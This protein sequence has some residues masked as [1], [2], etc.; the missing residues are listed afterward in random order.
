[1]I[2]LSMLNDEQK[3]AVLDFDHNLL[4]L[5]CAG[6]G[7]TRTITAKIAYA[8]SE[9]IYKP[10]Q[11]L[12]VT[13]TNRAANEM[14]ER[15]AQYLPDEDL[16]GLEMRTFHSFG[17]Y[18]LRRNYERAGLP[19]DFCIYDDADSV[20]LLS[21]VAAM[22]KRELRQAMKDISNLKD[23]GVMPEDREAA[24]AGD[25]SYDLPQLYLK[26]QNALRKTGNVDFADL[27]LKPYELLRDDEEVR[28]RYNSR[29]RM[30]LVD[31]YQ[32]SN[33]MQFRLLR[34]LAGPDTQIVAVGDDDQSIYSFRGAAIENILTFS[35]SFENVREIKLEKN[36]RST[37]QI[38]SPA[39]AL[40]AHNTERHPKSLISADDKTGPKP[41]LL[42][43]PDAR[44]EG[45][46]IASIIGEI[47]D[48]D[49]TAIL[50]RTNAQSLIFEQ[51]LT[52]RRI[53]FKLIGALRFY[54]RE[55]IK[56]SLAF[57]Y[58]LLNHRDEI[59]FRRIVNKPARGLGEQKIS[60]ILSLSDDIK[61]GLRLFVSTASGAAA[62]G[63][64]LFL[65]AWDAADKSLDMDG[66]LGEVL[67]KAL[68][69][70]GLYG[71]YQ[72]ESDKAVRMTKLDN[73]GTLVSSLQEAG[74]GREDLASFL[75]KITLDATMIGDNDPADA[76]GVTLIT[77]HNT[78]GLEF[79]RVFIA[80]LE[81]GII[82]GRNGEDREA[83]EERRILYVAMTRARKYLYLSY[84]D[85]RMLWGRTEMQRPSR[86]LREIPQDMIAADLRSSVSQRPYSSIVN[87]PSW[88]SGISFEKPKVQKVKPRN[89]YGT[90]SVGDD[91]TNP[92]FGRGKVIEID[93]KGEGRRVITVRFGKSTAKFIE[94]FAK[95]EKS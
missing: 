58:L 8:I 43:N 85:R 95:L 26:Y 36:Y 27:I 35:S 74:N 20:S 65:S 22:E 3:E 49:N 63:A 81:D 7:K 48:Y 4:L 21:T 9:G 46:R 23:R 52:E 62:A 32:D 2:D 94:A 87:T 34:Q 57:L 60:R 67:R 93:D 68:D 29:F 42:R 53:P 90:F 83:E 28:T 45:V 78:K 13:F 71:L 18:M 69:D 61:E 72:S 16:S 91:V 12:A 44:A 41:Q 51:I 76:K 73:L 89:E 24:R 30:I 10:Y 1:M 66:N 88:A 82:P 79:D 39:A 64:S 59:S 25:G 92:E 5:A 54:E 19:R 70:T 40:I 75:E 37:Q 38:L 86:F 84:A 80:G 15:V 50:Y 55:E 6:S 33:T 11:I 17:A 14:R 56:D 31:E 77:M 47:G